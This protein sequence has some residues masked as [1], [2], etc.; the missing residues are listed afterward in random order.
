MKF[1]KKFKEIYQDY[2]AMGHVQ[3]GDLE[4][5]NLVHNFRKDIKIYFDPNHIKGK[6]NQKAI[7]IIS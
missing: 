1:F 5:I 2:R 6:F 4:T 7:I 3:D